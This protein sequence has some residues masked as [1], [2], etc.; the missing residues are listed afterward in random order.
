MIAKCGDGFRLAFFAQSPRGLTFALLRVLEFLRRGTAFWLGFGRLGGHRE[1]GRNSQ[2]ETEK[3]NHLHALPCTGYWDRY[4]YLVGR[5][6]GHRIFR[7][8]CNDSNYK[9]IV[10]T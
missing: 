9:F 2:C 7:R 1:H 4:Q 8:C 6:L 10:T 5:L 3:A